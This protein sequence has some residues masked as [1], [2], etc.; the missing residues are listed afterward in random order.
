MRETREY[1]RSIRGHHPII[2]LFRP[3]RL[4]LD[5]SAGRLRVGLAREASL[6]D[7][8]RSMSDQSVGDAPQQLADAMA[9]AAQT[10]NEPEDVGEVLDRLVRVACVTIPGVDDAGVSIGSK[11]G[12][13]TMASIGSLVEE[14]DQLQYDSGEG[15][16]LQAMADGKLRSLSIAPFNTWSECRRTATLHFAISFSR[17]STRSPQTHP[18]S[19]TNQKDS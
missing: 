13:S 16:C 9:A 18:P 7:G 15:P 14:C 12:V 10:L 5:S 4:R 2:L 3:G 11:S 19:A 17:S 6:L 8:G 1:I